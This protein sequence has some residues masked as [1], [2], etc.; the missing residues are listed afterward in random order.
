M[1]C[2]KCN[3]E[4][5]G[6]T[7]FCPECGW[8]LRE[9]GSNAAWI[10]ATQEKIKDARH[11]ATAFTTGM[12]GFMILA[13]VFPILHFG[14][15]MPMDS[16]MWVLTTVCIIVAILCVVGHVHYDDKAK[17]LITRLERGR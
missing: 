13:G 17:E 10:A 14:L 11:T 3:S 8:D 9:K 16:T 5:S 2:P 7:K 1:V 4:V 6:T 15:G 12:V